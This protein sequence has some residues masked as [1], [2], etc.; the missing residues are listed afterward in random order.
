MD[1]LTLTPS[2]AAQALG[3]SR[4]KIYELVHTNNFPAVRL[5]KKIVI[6]AERLQEWLREQSQKSDDCEVH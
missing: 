3:V 4:N 5:G 2:E 6:P 1:R